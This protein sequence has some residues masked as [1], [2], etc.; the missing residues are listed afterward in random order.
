MSKNKNELLDSITVNGITIYSNTT[1]H[2]GTQVYYARILP[3]VGICYVQTIKV[4]SIYD[5]VFIGVDAVTKM[6]PIIENKYLGVTAFTD[7]KHA[8]KLVKEAQ[9]SGRVK[10]FKERKDENGDD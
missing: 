4:R 10:Q 9:K 8:E 3:T 5:D 7:R 6:S 2:Q 1:E